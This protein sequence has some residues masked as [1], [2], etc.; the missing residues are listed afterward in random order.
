VFGV[1]VFW[2]YLTSGFFYSLFLYWSCLDTLPRK[3]WHSGAILFQY[4]Y[5]VWKF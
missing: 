4:K 1:G 5:V 3:G 2:I